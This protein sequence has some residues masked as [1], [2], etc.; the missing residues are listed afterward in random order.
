MAVTC[1]MTQSTRG[2][3]KDGQADPDGE[4]FNHFT[5]TAPQELRDLFLEN[6]EVKDLDYE[7]FSRACDDVAE[8]DLRDL[9]GSEFTGDFAS[10]YTFD[11]LQ[12]LDNNNQDEISEYVKSY[13]VDIATACAIW[14]DERVNSACGLIRDY[15][16]A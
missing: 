12:Y 2:K 15:V 6:F 14:Y 10:V 3:A 11:R 9:E 8:V 16:L 5:D 13:E 1:A 7:I 4:V